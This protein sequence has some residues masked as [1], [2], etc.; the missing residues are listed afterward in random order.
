MVGPGGGG[1]GG[2]NP[3]VKN[4]VLIAVCLQFSYTTSLGFLGQGRKSDRPERNA[5]EAVK[6][7][8]FLF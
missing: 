1:G 4:R 6:V 8:H 3:T 5:D 2:Q 7:V